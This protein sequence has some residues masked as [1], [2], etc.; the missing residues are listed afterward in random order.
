MSTAF[1]PSGFSS[2]WRNST[3][4]LI[5][6]SP[7]RSS[8]AMPAA[9][10]PTSARVW[11]RRARRNETLA[12]VGAL[13]AG[14]AHE[15]RNGLNPI[16][17]SVEYLQ[18]ELK[19]EGEGAVL[20]ELIV[21][22]CARLNRFVTD[23]LNYARERDLAFEPLALDGHLAE[24]REGLQRDPRTERVRLA[25][26]AP[27]EGLVVRADRQQLRQVWLNLANNALDAMAEAGGALTVRWRAQGPGRVVIEFAD[28]G[29]GIPAE[30]LPRV[31][32]PFF[33]TKQGGTGLGVAIAQRIVERH[34]G[35]LAFE[36]RLG[37]GTVARVVLPAQPV[38]AVA[39]AA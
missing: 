5:G 39:D 9:S 18:R 32:E 3:E 15:L 12:E 22:E 8:W 33:T 35:T 2:R 38:E 17:G 19:P 36:S 14:I 1:S 23:L 13:A 20:M 31:G 28:L 30:V 37:R 27:P 21:R 24:L 10:A 34:G 7:L 25:F 4:P 26:E 11:L 29:P 6:L 16:S